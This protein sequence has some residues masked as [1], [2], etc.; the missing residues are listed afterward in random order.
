MQMTKSQPIEMGEDGVVQLPE[1]ISR[2]L[3]VF[4]LKHVPWASTEQHI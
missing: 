2:Y 1:T 3:H 4:L